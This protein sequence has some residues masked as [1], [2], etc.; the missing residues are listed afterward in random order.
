MYK[1]TQVDRIAVEVLGA[2]FEIG[3]SP[4]LTL[5]MVIRLPCEVGIVT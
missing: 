3:L 1:L 4:Y 2:D 5:T